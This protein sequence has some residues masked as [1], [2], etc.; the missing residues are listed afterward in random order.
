MAH[1]E[2]SSAQV[3]CNGHVLG[4]I[5]YSSVDQAGILAWESIE[6]FTTAGS[7]LAHVQITK[8]GEIGVVELNKSAA[9][10]GQSFD[11]GT[12]CSSQILEEVIEIGVSL[13]IN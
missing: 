2:V 1:S 5:A 3:N 6:V 13:D 7:S 11:L 9:C 4:C 12:V 8:I 10:L